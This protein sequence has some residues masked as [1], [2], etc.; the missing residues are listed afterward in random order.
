LSSSTFYKF[1]LAGMVLRREVLGDPFTGAPANL[2]LSNQS[3]ASA[4]PGSTEPWNEQSAEKQLTAHFSIVHQLHPNHQFKAGVEA[5]LWDLSLHRVRYL[6]WPNVEDKTGFIYSRYR[7][8]FRQFPFTLA[9]YYNHK[10]EKNNF[11]LN[12]GLRYEAFSP[13]AKQPA[14]LTADSTNLFTGESG[15][16]KET[17]A[18][19]LSLAVP[20]SR[21]E[22][23]SFNYGWFYELP[24]LYYLYL[25]RSGDREAT[26]PIF[27]NVDLKPL[28]SRAWEVT[29]RRVVSPQSLYSLTY[30]YRSYVDLLDTSPYTVSASNSAETSKTAMRFENRARAYTSGLE[31]AIKHDFGQ[32]F[33]GA[34]L[35]T[36]LHCTGTASWPESNLLR[37]AR[38]ENADE[39]TDPTALDWTQRH[40][41][42]FTLG[43]L[44]RTGWHI[45]VLGRINSPAAYTDWLSG[46]QD[47]LSARHDLDVKIVAPVRWA[48]LP[49][50]PFL[51]IHNVLDGKYITPG[52]GGLDLSQPNSLLR[53][54]F[55]RQIWVG[56]TYR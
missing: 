21:N 6:L 43:Y 5:N 54:Q 8:A 31:L 10:I 49:V 51:E 17:L 32:G 27:G 45:N 50:E 42:N 14:V 18:P 47:K 36:Y 1:D 26:L 7:D 37:I 4:W 48:G 46:A 9:G 40:T 3:L 19:R 38:G 35:Y 12:L 39:N 2:R 33:N 56:I 41:F 23:L 11:I 16:F 44:S 22:H 29:Y 28:R 55:G 25:N 30:F 24:P 20:V 13:H 34:L 15:Q 52:E 53:N